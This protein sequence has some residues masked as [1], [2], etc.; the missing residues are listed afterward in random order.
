VTYENGTGSARH[1]ICRRLAA[2]S[3]FSG[4]RHLWADNQH[5]RDMAMSKLQKLWVGVYLILRDYSRGE[6]PPTF[7][8]QQETYDAEI[9]SRQK[10]GL[11]EQTLRRLAMKKPFW[12]PGTVR[13]YLSAH[14]A[15][16]RCLE[17]A[18]VHPPARLLDLGCGSGWM[19][20]FLAIQG[21]RVVGINISPNEVAD[22]ELRIQ[23]AHVRAIEADMEFRVAPM[24]RAHE[25]VDDLPPFDAVYAYEALHHAYDWKATLKS[26]CRCL[27]QGGSLFLF[28]EPNVLHTFV[29]YRSSR[30]RNN[31]EIGFRRR[32][33]IHELRKIGFS[34]IR[35]MKNRLNLLCTPLWI[36]ARR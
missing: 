13:H 1:A 25:A 27:R 24:E 21:Y 18:G 31:H 12:S 30:L 16:T 35:V 6:F 22:A 34:D 36:S 9:A 7:D 8:N 15:V 5:D 29:A 19:A 11:D 26:A 20:E 28:H 14:I 2:S 23:G 10:K 4:A 32:R 3:L 17:K 33:V